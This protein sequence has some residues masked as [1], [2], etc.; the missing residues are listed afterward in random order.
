MGVAFGDIRV[1]HIRVSYHR[2]INRIQI[3]HHFSSILCVHVR[4]EGRFFTRFNL[5]DTGVCAVNQPLQH[6]VIIIHAL[7]DHDLNPVTGNLQ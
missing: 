2:L 3:N 7:I 1:I 5:S 4:R 6:P